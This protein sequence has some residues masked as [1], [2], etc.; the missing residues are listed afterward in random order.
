MKQNRIADSI[1]VAVRRDLVQLIEALPR[2]PESALTGRCPT[3]A[4]A[5]AV[6]A[7]PARPVGR[8]MPDPMPPTQ[9]ST[10]NAAGFSPPPGFQR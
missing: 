3:V 9:R 5:Q 4:E 8:A 10:L 7:A 1:A 6:I 2:I